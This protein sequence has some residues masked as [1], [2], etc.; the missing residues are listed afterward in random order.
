MEGDK[1]Y[2]LIM[3]PDITSCVCNEKQGRFFHYF[4]D[5]CFIPYSVCVCVCVC[6]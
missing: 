3:Q 6:E 1:D 5:F 4:S 2:N